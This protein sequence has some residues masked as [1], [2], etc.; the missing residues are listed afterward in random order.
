[1]FDDLGTKKRSCPIQQPNV[2]GTIGEAVYLAAQQSQIALALL[3][4]LQPLVKQH[5]HVHV[6]LGAGRPFGHRT[7]QIG[8]H[9]VRLLGE[10]VRQACHVHTRLALSGYCLCLLLR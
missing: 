2:K 7:E 6:T 10:K 1:M 5:S 8:D 9:H 3:P 4:R